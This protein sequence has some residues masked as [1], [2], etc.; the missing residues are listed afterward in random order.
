MASDGRH[1]APRRR[2]LEPPAIVN[3]PS[4]GASRHVVT[5]QDG[6]CLAM[7][8]RLGVPTALGRDHGD[9]PGLRVTSIDSVRGRYSGPAACVTGRISAPEGASGIPWPSG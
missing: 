2:C 6:E 1:A 4:S 8:R 3:A 7:S 9:E 5:G